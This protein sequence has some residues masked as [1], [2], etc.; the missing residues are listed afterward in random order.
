VGECCNLLYTIFFKVH[1]PDKWDWKLNTQEGYTTS[2][3]YHLLSNLK[4]SL[5]YYLE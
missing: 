1:V 4:H 5:R 2:G 3:V